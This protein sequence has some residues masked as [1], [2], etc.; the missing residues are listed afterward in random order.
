MKK[1][2]F[3]ADTCIDCQ[4]LMTKEKEKPN[5][6]LD[7]DLD[8]ININETIGNLKKFLQYRDKLDGYKSVK[9]NGKV[10]VPS[11]VIDEKEVVILD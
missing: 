5:L 1:E 4:E 2:L 8:I 11:I 10:G 6:V 7:K 9:E 3:I